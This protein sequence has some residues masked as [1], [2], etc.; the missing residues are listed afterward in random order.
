MPLC[1]S[2]KSLFIVGLQ[3]EPQ[4]HNCKGAQVAQTPRKSAADLI[5]C[6]CHTAF[7][8]AVRLGAARLE[9]SCVSAIAISPMERAAIS[10]RAAPNDGSAQGFPVRLAGSH[11]I[12]FRRQP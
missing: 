5:V 7:P 12:H 1:A 2:V 3:R 8:G 11:F 9:A 10:P 4:V 6:G